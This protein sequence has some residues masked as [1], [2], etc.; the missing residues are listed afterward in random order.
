[1]TISY[2]VRRA[3]ADTTLTQRVAVAL[4]CLSA[5]LSASSQATARD[6]LSEIV[7][8]LNM[9]YKRNGREVVIK[10]GTYGSVRLTIPPTASGTRSD[11]IIIRAETKHGVRFTN[12]TKIRV[13]GNHVVLSG[14][15]FERVRHAAVVIS[16]DH[17]RLEKSSFVNSGNPRS[18]K[19]HIVTI[20]S[21]GQ[22]NVIRGNLFKASISMSIGVRDG[23]ASDPEHPVHN[24]ILNNRFV[25]IKRLS[26]NGQEAIQLAGP[27]GGGG[28]VML[29]TLIEGNTF[30]RAEGDREAISVKTPGTTIRGNVFRDMDASINLRGGSD[31]LVERN[32]LVNTRP[33]RVSGARNRLINNIIVRPRKG[34]GIQLS[35]RT[36]GYQRAEDSV[37]LHNTIF[38]SKYG[39]IVG[40]PGGRDSSNNPVRAEPA[41][42]IISNNIIVLKH[43]ERFVHFADARNAIGANK[44]HNNLV[45]STAAS[46]RRK[47]RPII[48]R[49]GNVLADPKLRWENDVAHLRPD[50][51]ARGGAEPGLV[52][53]DHF[54]HPRPERA[55]I[56]AVQFGVTATQKKTR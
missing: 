24:K 42:N 49:S 35:A 38:S 36:R 48:E 16:G 22:R 9:P 2:C 54:G 55:D 50:S 19:S 45:W 28:E 37:V 5:S 1:M 44:V 23:P 25:D 39:V 15:A 43:A 3:S 30:E 4:L 21:T 10:N 31:N 20:T 18:T 6:P 7:T 27:R 41:R 11:P 53:T 13:D 40:F 46:N 12:T 8:Q 51:A 33:I 56:G 34:F 17:N 29:H 14:F 26:N 52:E 47:A 32:L